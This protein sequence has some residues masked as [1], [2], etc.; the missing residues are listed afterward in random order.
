MP[1]TDYFDLRGELT[2]LEGEGTELHQQLS[3]AEFQKHKAESEIETSTHTSGVGADPPVAGFGEPDPFEEFSR[4][5][6]PWPAAEALH[7]R[8]KPQRLVAGHQWIDRGILEGD[9][10]AA[11]NLVRLGGD[12][13]TRN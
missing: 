3:D 5:L 8:L 7:D 2:E 10:D 6:L 9:P 13:E 11:A 1:V 12:I 4:P